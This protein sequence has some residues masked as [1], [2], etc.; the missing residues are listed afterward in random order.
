MK[1]IGFLGVAEATTVTGEVVVT[2]VDGLE[3]V[4]GKSLEALGGAVAGG[5][6]SGLDDGDHVMGTGGEEGELGWEGGV[7]LVV[8]V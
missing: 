4:S 6:G 1:K 7:G 5:A 2:P 8:V 3:M